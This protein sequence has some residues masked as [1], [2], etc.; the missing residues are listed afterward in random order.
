MRSEWIN[1]TPSTLPAD[2]EECSDVGRLPQNGTAKTAQNSDPMD[3]GSFGSAAPGESLNIWKV[4][5]PPASLDVPCTC[6]EKSYP[7]FQHRDGTGPGSGRGPREWRKAQPVKMSW[8]DLKKLVTESESN[9][10]D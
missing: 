10:E 3:S 7:H 2:T 9:K 6:A 5:G 4:E 1:W 8:D